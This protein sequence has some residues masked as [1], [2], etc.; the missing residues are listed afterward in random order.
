MRQH[1]FSLILT[2]V[3]GMGTIN[4]AVIASGNCG[5]SGSGSTSTISNN[6]TWT[7]TDDG[8]LTIDGTGQISTYTVHWSSYQ[9]DITKVIIGEGITGFSGAPNSLFRY[10][11]YLTAVEWHAINCNYSS[12][13][14]IFSYYD[15]SPIT[16]FTFGNNVQTIPQYLCRGLVN[17]TSIT[18]PNTVTSIGASAFYYCTSL[19]ELVIPASVTSI[20]ASAFYYCTSLSELVIPASVTSIGASAFYN[21]SIN[22]V[23]FEGLTPPTIDAISFDV[24]LV[25]TAALDAYKAAFPDKANRIVA[26]NPTINHQ[27]ITVTAQSDKSAIHMAIGEANLEQVLSLKVNGTINSYDIMIIRNKM[28][29]LLELDLSDADIVANS[30]EYYT[31]ICSQDNVLSERAFTSTQIHTAKLPR[32]LTYIKRNIFN[33]TKLRNLEINSGTLNDSAFYDTN[34]L[35]T[36]RINNATLGQ[37]SFYS[38]QLRYLELNNI[39][40][41]P[42]YCFSGCT[43]LNNVTLPN[44]LTHIE[45][46]AFR[47]CSALQN[48]TLPSSLVHIGGDAFAGSGLTSITIPASVSYIG[49]YAFAGGSNRSYNISGAGL[50]YKKKSVVIKEGNYIVFDNGDSYSGYYV[51]LQPNKYYYINNYSVYN[52]KYENGE[53]Y[54][55]YNNQTWYSISTSN[56]KNIFYVEQEN[57]QLVTV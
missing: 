32:S 38:S 56:Q 48:I 19:S 45:D 6:V 5:Y 10:C 26:N 13:N 52:A 54:Y 3:M 2:L 43:K 22:K 9:N 25:P 18:L 41:I 57:D 53:Y 27:E 42:N 31:G 21:C 14:P 24:A 4:A 50:S 20:G 33:S 15:N 55:Y 35:D 40:T 17:V 7:L 36:V 51:D 16:S 12:P 28:I 37:C 49:K 46:G 29:N 8:T 1:L 39:T 23:I 47:S 34:E 11:Q 44:N 30:Y